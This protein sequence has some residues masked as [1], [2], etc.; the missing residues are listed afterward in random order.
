[1]FFQGYVVCYWIRH[2]TRVFCAGALK[3]TKQDLFNIRHGD[4]PDVRNVVIIIAD[5]ESNVDPLQ[6]S[7]AARRLKEAMARLYVVSGRVSGVG[8][9]R[10]GWGL[11]AEQGGAGGWNCYRRVGP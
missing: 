8:V 1:M 4:R 7:R 11:G 6:T 9:G 3:Q 10:R 2:V 5:G